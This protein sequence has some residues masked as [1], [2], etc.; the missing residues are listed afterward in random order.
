MH[1]FTLLISLLDMYV[2][3]L[4]KQVYVHNNRSIFITTI[5]NFLCSIMI[6]ILLHLSLSYPLPFP[7]IPILIN[8]LAFYF[9]VYEVLIVMVQFLHL[10]TLRQQS[11]QLII[12]PFTGWQIL[13]KHQ[14]ILEWH[15]FEFFGEVQKQSRTNIAME[16]RKAFVF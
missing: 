4:S 15:V 1:S 10:I 8:L 5:F 13:Q 14:G 9:L 3:E 6:L 2:N 11:I 12:A 7:S 16:L